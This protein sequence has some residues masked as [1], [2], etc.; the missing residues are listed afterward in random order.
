M[1]QRLIPGVGLV[2]LAYGGQLLPGGVVQERAT[3]TAALA[4]QESGSDT[5]A[6]TAKVAVSVA[7]AAG[8][9]GADA[10][11]AS[12]VVIVSAAATAQETAADA[13]DFTVEVVGAVPEPPSVSP[14]GSGN[15]IWKPRRGPRGIAPAERPQEPPKPLP[16][17]ATLHAQEAGDDAAAVILRLPVRAVMG[18]MSE[19]PYA[20]GMWL[21]LEVFPSWEEMSRAIT[22]GI[23]GLDVAA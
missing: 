3:I 16:V 10:A 20:D 22:A 4:A 23:F 8:E 21:P 6:I 1:S 19:A 9:S 18:A 17:A 14:G 11:A 15:I 12:A 7:T 2:D 5:A 13:A